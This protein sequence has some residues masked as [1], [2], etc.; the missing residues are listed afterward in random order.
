[1]PVSTSSV[2][3]ISTMFLPFSRYTNVSMCKRKGETDRT[4]MKAGPALSDET[5]PTTKGY[6]KHFR[7]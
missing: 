1:M 5:L 7:L 6:F 4:E 2:K 3:N